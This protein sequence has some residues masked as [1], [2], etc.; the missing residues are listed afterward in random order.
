[1]DSI[2]FALSSVP[3]AISSVYRHHHLSCILPHNNK[4]LSRRRLLFSDCIS[5]SRRWAALPSATAGLTNSLPVCLP[6]LFSF[7]IY[8]CMYIYV[9]MYQSVHFLHYAPSNCWFFKFF[10]EFLLLKFGMIL[11]NRIKSCSFRVKFAYF[12]PSQTETH[13]RVKLYQESDQV[14][15]GANE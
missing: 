10:L 8:L 4:C 7:H 15:M 1:M 9:C 6:S 11:S 14:K 5:G 13:K 2:I 3:L 12:L